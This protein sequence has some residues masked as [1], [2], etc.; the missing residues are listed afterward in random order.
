MKLVHYHDRHE[1]C[2]ADM[3]TRSRARTD[4]MIVGRRA[5]S[6]SRRCW[7]AAARQPKPQQAAAAAADGD[8]RQAGQAHDRRPGRICRPL[9]RG[10]TRSRCARACRAISTR[11]IS[12]TA[13]WSS[14]AICCSPSTSGR[15]R[16]R[17]TRRA[18]ISSS[19][20]RPIWPSPRPIWRAP[21]SS[22]ATGPSPSRCSTSARRPFRNAAGLG[23]GERGAG[24]A[25]RA[26]SR[27]HRAARA[28]RRPHRRPARVARQSGHR[29]HRRQHHAA[30]HHRLDRSD[31]LR[32]HLRRGLAPALRAAGERRQGRDRPRHQPPVAAEAD[33]RAGLYPLRP[34]GLRRQR[35]RPR[36]RH[37]PRPR[38]SSPM[39]TACSRPACSRACRCRARR[40]TR[41]CWCPMPRSA[42]SRRANTCSW[43][44]PTT[45][46]RS[47]T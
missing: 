42:P 22:C 20:R 24:A 6:A 4:S 43:S 23:G 32:I 38:V 39:P 27:I 21:S 47:D 34:H 13:R 40:L 33:R 41:R 36:H 29:R 31:P 8:G 15:S 5:L 46:Q 45:R 30:R 1:P 7:R 17:S 10:A 11:C 44:V 25:G 18:P 12:R 3:R 9:R 28:G 35:D 37:D 16:T 26:R 14:R 2:T 19:A